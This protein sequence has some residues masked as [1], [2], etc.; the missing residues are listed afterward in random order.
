MDQH[1]H[2]ERGAIMAGRIGPGWRSAMWVI[3]NV[4]GT[5]DM[6]FRNRCKPEQSLHIK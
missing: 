6:Q 3:K 1:L 2:I 5:P 4:P